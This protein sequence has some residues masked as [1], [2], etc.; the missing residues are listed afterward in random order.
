R[1]A[2]HEVGQR[3]E[4]WTM[5]MHGVEALGLRLGDV[6]HLHADNAELVF[7]ERVDDVAGGAALEGVRLDD[8]KSALDGFH[9]IWLFVFVSCD[10]S[11]RISKR[12]YTSPACGAKELSP[13]L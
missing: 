6:Q 3:L 1:S 10:I 12:Q 13:A 9:I 8:G 5:H 7:Q 11:H 4:E 2:R